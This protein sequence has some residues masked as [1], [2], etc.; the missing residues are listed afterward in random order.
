MIDDEGKQILQNL[1]KQQSK[2]LKELSQFYC[3]AAVLGNKMI[4]FVKLLG[5]DP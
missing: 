4:N 1:T 5:S 2:I 3:K